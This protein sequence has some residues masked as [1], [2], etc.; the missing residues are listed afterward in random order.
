MAKIKTAELQKLGKAAVVGG[1]VA[2]VL[3]IIV[4]L[5]SRMIDRVPTRGFSALEPVEV[6]VACFVA[7][8]CAAVLLW[9]LRAFTKQAASI[10]YLVVVILLVV[11]IADPLLR[12]FRDLV[13]TLILAAMYLICAG[14]IIG[15][16]QRLGGLKK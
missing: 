4:L 12:D 7:A 9:A 5:L 6:L 1:A 13:R 16:F 11:L 15:A 2:S 3:N 14:S 10:F 8:L